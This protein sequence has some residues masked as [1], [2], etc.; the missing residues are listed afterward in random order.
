MKPLA[1]NT[2]DIGRRR[3]AGASRCDAARGWTPAACQVSYRPW[4][5]DMDDVTKEM[6]TDEMTTQDTDYLHATPFIDSDNPA[7]VAFAQNALGDARYTA[8]FDEASGY[9][10]DEAANLALGAARHGTP[11]LPGPGSPPSGPLTRREHQIAELIAEGMANK[12][13]A[14]HLVISRRTAESHVEHILA[15][16]GL[17]TRTQVTGWIIER[18]RSTDASP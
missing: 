9:S 2:R 13:I 3:K 1:S 6:T 4:M 14:A 15:K 10:L 7:I 18:R 5:P 8:V 11:A 17:T 16:L 12:D